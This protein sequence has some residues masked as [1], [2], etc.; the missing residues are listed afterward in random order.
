MFQHVAG[1][2]IFLEPRGSHHYASRDVVEQL[3]EVDQAVRQARGVLF[4]A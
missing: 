2:T 4:A 3:V 1:Q